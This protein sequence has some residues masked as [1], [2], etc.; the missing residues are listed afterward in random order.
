MPFA[1]EPPPPYP[2]RDMSDASR[3]PTQPTTLDALVEVA[4]AMAAHGPRTI[5]GIAGSPGA[6]K[7]TLAASLVAALDADA[8]LVPMDGFHLAQS[9]LA[10]LGRADRKG[11]PD[12]FDALGYVDLLR[13][14]RRNDDAL[15]YAPRFD[16]HLE[17]P[18]ACAIPVARDVPL[19]VTEG[20]YLLL[21]DGDWAGVAPLLDAC[22]FVDA[23][24][25]TRVE[26]LIA[27]H[28]AHGRS[29]DAARRWTLGPDQRNA[30]LVD[31]TRVRASL[32]V[33]PVTDAA[34]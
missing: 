12:T 26:R 11:A 7:S 3:P 14:L 21:D 19:V 28:V 22:W 23:G 5:L 17:E 25:T 6:G 16:R 10:R 1:C 2:G 13:R 15:V 8:V 27:R 30:Q 31:A 4:R 18:I 33:R 29:P 24:E 20:N 32:V 34:R 9:E